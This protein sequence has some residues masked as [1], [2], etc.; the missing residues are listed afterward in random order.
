MTELFLHKSIVLFI[1]IFMVLIGKY[2]SV[3][4]KSRSNPNT[5][6]AFFFVMYLIIPVMASPGSFINS[7]V[8]IYM[9]SALICF[10]LPSLIFDWK[11]AKSV[12]NLKSYLWNNRRLDLLGFLLFV[13]IVIASFASLI[14][15]MQQG[16]SLV[17]IFLEPLYV[18][19]RIGSLRYSGELT[20][21]VYSILGSVFV[22]PIAFLSGLLFRLINNRKIL[23][24]ISGFSV[25]AFVM[26]LQSS[27]GM[28]FLSAAFFYCGYLV[29][30]VS[31]GD[32]RFFPRLNFL[33]TIAILFAV[34]SLLWYSFISRLS[35]LTV[36]NQIGAVGDYLI[37][38][39]CSHVYAFSDWLS[40]RYFGGGIFD[41]DQPVLSMGFYTFMPLFE[42]VGLGREIPIGTYG[43][44][45]YDESFRPGNIYTVFRGLI[46][47]YSF[48]GSICSFFLFGFLANYSYFKMITKSMPIGAWVMYS[49]FFTAAYQSYAA[50]TLSWSSTFIAFFI[51]YISLKISV[52]RTG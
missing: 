33:S 44:Y 48:M 38:Y 34:V 20:F 49:I 45:F 11:Y 36:D 12:G 17:E 24:L 25:P 29:A 5:V 46:S 10:C 16:F 28:F 3:R 27:K 15:V 14:F 35:D 19:S 42:L 41:Y 32:Y 8:A 43:E 47:D 2:F 26:I 37:S 13:Y 18:A 51:M 22:Y 21:S 6:L 1:V 4:C 23:Y 52:L 30:R 7:I 39:C 31:S 9:L 50:S 40:D